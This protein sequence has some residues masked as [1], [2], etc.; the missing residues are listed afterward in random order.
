MSPLE[1]LQQIENRIKELEIARSQFNYTDL[2]VLNLTLR[3]LN[4]RKKILIGEAT[5]QVIQEKKDNHDIDLI[6]KE[7]FRWRG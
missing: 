3:H 5:D 4:N 6:E 2:S 7:D 1:E